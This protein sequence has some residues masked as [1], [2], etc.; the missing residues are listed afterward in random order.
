M[1]GKSTFLR[2]NALISVLAQTGCFVPA[3]FAEIG[4]VDKMFS[5]V[6]D[7]SSA[8]HSYVDTA[9][10]WI[11]RQPLSRPVNIHGG[12]VG[13]GRNPETGNSSLICKNR[14]RSELI[15]TDIDL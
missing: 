12:D 10:G 5:R 8:G 2:Q 7:A 15:R 11:R 4:L 3:E 1:A 14:R 9:S 6:S 13:D